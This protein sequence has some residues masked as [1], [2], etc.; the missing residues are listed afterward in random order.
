MAH[1]ILSHVHVPRHAKMARNLGVY[2]DAVY[3]GMAS[4]TKPSTS[5]QGSRK[6]R[7]TQIGWGVGMSLVH[8]HRTSNYFSIRLVD[9]WVW[10]DVDKGS[11][12]VPPQLRAGIIEAELARGGLDPNPLKV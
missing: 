9:L 1:P 6:P 4:I 7:P 8:S 2:F 3:Q 12:A 11:G 5:S 10:L